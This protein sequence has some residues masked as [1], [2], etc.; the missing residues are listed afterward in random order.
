MEVF[1]VTE[2]AAYLNCSIS[3]IRKLISTNKIPYFR[4]GYRIL[5]RKLA[6]DDW[7]KQQELEHNGLI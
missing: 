3:A 6:L 5:F 7:I 1:N 4:I 2:A